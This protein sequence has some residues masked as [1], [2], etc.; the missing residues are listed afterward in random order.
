MDESIAL[1]AAFPMEGEPG[2]TFHYS[3][4]GLQIAAA[5]I[6]KISG[7]SFT[8]LFAERIAKPCNM[9]N[10]DFGDKKVPLPAGGARSTPQDY[11]NF[12]T[13][14]LNNGK[15]NGKQILS[16]NSVAAMQKNYAKNAK[17]LYTPANATATGWGYGL[18]EWTMDDADKRSNAVTSPGAFGS[19]PWVDNEKGY[20]GFLF[21]F[22]LKSEGRGEKLLALKH[23]TDEAITGK[24]S[25][26]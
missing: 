10:T 1:I 15:F 5:V 20:A 11:I 22:N 26:Q 4:A 21:V 25:Q 3:S 24:T 17:V 14:I 7:K 6:E 2:K 18:G 8:S 12:L 23:L 9:V 13:M 19:F 16:A